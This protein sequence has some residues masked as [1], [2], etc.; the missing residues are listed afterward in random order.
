FAAAG[1][2][3]DQIVDDLPRGEARIGG[4]VPVGGHLVWLQQAHLAAPGYYDACRLQAFDAG[5]LGIGQKVGGAGLAIPKP[6]LIKPDDR[7]AAVS[8]EIAVLLGQRLVENLVDERQ[9]TADS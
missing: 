3:S 2:Y 1:E 7:K 4:R 8:I 5:H 6:V 9:R